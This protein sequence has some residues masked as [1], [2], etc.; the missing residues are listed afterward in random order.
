MKNKACKTLAPMLDLEIEK[1]ERSACRSVDIASIPDESTR[2]VFESSLAWL[3]NFVMK[4]HAELGRRGEV[5]PFAKPAHYRGSLV[6]CAWN[7]ED[8]SFDT[9]LRILNSLP[10]VYYR[11]LTQSRLDARFFSVYIHVDNLKEE[12]YF[13]YID[14]AHSL[15][16]PGF[17]AAG[18][19]IGEFHPLSKTEGV[20]SK[21]F[22]PMRSPHPAFVLRAITPHDA[23]FIDQDN[24]PAEVRLRELLSYKQWVEKALPVGERL[25]IDTR[26]AELSRA[27]GKPA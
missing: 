15:T 9:F 19:M 26:I 7:A 14:D 13:K 22:R 23:L 18:L 1:I 20:H 5:C 16:K 3:E 4:P 12:Q 25:K 27:S 17:M 10:A 11:I 6:F 21:A 8:L 24:S 2:K